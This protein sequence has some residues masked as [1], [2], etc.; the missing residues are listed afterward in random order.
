MRAYLVRRGI[1]TD[2]ILVDS[3]GNDTWS[4][5]RDASDAM[6]KQRLSSAIVV[7]Q[8]FHLPR[9]M[10]ALKRYGVSEVSGAYP[11]F[12]EVRDIY[13]VVREV[14]AFIWYAIRPLIPP[15][16]PLRARPR[17]QAA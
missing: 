4:T 11:R 16:N 9:A 7:T 17:D 15:T 6:R 1:P 14:P 12:W 13:S 3:A 5:A 10:L 2:H 8:Y